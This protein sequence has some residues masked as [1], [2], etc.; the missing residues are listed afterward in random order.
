M[1]DKRSKGG[2]RNPRVFLTETRLM[3]AGGVNK[4]MLVKRTLRNGLND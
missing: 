2:D 1:D 4:I 3:L